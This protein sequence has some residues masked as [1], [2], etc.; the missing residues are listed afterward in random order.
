ERGLQVPH[1]LELPRMLCAVVPLVRGQRRS[2][3]VV[4]EL[5]ALA[6]GHAVG[7][8]GFAGRRAGLVPGL[9]AVV[10]A[11]NDLP[12]P[13][14]RLRSVD[15][16]GIGRRSFEVIEL[17]AGEERAADFP[18]VSLAVG[19]EDECAFARANQNADLAH[20]VSFADLE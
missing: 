8:L 11:L 2:R 20:C 19:C 16:V 3:R 12:E 17:P 6:L 18:L 14:T 9:A 7:A 4:D 13:A 10:G 15:A 1:P 5:V